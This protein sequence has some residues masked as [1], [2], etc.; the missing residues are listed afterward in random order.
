[1]FYGVYFVE[2]K[3]KWEMHSSN[4]LFLIGSSEISFK[5]YKKEHTNLTLTF[6]YKE[7]NQTMKVLTVIQAERVANGHHKLTHSQPCT[8]PHSH[9]P[10]L[11]VFAISHLHTKNTNQTFSK[12]PLHFIIIFFNERTSTILC[13]LGYQLGRMNHLFC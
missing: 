2:K 9:R 4:H 3:Q 7:I 13:P 10:P 8:G 1:M 5:P 12:P 6:K 11:P